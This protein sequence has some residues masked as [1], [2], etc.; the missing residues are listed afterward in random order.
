MSD[1]PSISTPFLP[2]SLMTV[3]SSFSFALAASLAALS[4]SSALGASSF[5]GASFFSFSFCGA[6]RGEGRRSQHGS[7]GG[8]IAVRQA[9]D[10]R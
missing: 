8:V 10:P 2:P 9:R 7:T 3:L 1:A 6:Q 4:A 5:L